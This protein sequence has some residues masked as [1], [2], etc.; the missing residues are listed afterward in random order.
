MI[1]PGKLSTDEMRDEINREALEIKQSILS[2]LIDIRLDLLTNRKSNALYRV[3]RLVDE[4]D[5]DI[6]IEL[7]TDLQTIR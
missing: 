4:L 6:K 2:E 5:K 7:S 3:T 1:N